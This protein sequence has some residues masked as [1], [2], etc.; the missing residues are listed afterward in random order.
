MSESALFLSGNV[1]TKRDLGKCDKVQV[2]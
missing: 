1:V 2:I